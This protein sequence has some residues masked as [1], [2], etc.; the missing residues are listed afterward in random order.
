MLQKNI[1]E[2]IKQVMIENEQLLL[3]QNSLSDK[4]KPITVDEVY[5][6][7]DQ[8]KRFPSTNTSCIEL[9][10]FISKLSIAINKF[11]MDF[12]KY[13]NN[14]VH[15]NGAGKENEQP[16]KIKA[17]DSLAELK[18]LYVEYTKDLSDEEKLI[19]RQVYC[20]L[21]ATKVREY[22]TISMKSVD[23]KFGIAGHVKPEVTKTIVSLQKQMHEAR[24]NNPNSWFVNEMYDYLFNSSNINAH[25]KACLEQLRSKQHCLESQVESE[26]RS[27]LD[28][29]YVIND[30]KYSFKD[31]YIALDFLKSRQE[32]YSQIAEKNNEIYSGLNIN[33][34]QSE[35]EKEHSLNTQQII[36]LDD[37]SYK[38]YIGSQVYSSY[39]A[40]KINETIKVHK[41][42]NQTENA[43]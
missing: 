15:S 39:R 43:Y 29:D 16:L 20:D 19:T 27:K 17:S 7:I 34:H 38:T 31:D 42:N 28:D 5:D 21:I 32:Y 10:K 23:G 37:K 9:C 11:N 18:K 2:N 13:A 33:T 4:S 25:A 8:M 26:F 36:K 40:Y 6:D 30:V 14:M 3:K 24:E 12:E 35:F 22:P 41:L 1:F